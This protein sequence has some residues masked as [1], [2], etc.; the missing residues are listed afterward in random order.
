MSRHKI[1]NYTVS[2]IDADSIW[3]FDKA[4]YVDVV[5]V[6][7][8]DQRV[9]VRYK[10]TKHFPMVKDIVNVKEQYLDVCLFDRTATY[11]EWMNTEM[12]QMEE[13]LEGDYANTPEE[14][15]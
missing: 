11:D 5:L 15:C 13:P 14:M 1:I 7:I 6:E 8:S 2:V 12:N 9:W 10:S 4:S 3:Y